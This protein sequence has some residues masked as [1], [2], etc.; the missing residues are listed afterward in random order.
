MG[1]KQI[2]IGQLIAPFG[3]GSLYTDRRGTPHVV[4]GLDH[5]FKRVDQVLGLVLC[6]KRAEFER[7]EPRL[8]D[9]LRVDR[10]CAPPDFRA[11]RRGE[12][13]PPNALLNV[14]AQRFPRWY[15]HTKTGRLRRF[16]LHT[17]KIDR[18]NDGGRYQ[19]V[20]FVSV[21]AGGHLSE[22]PWKEWIGCQCAGDGELVLTD[23]GGSELGSITVN[24]TSCPAGSTGRNGRSLAGTTAKP[25]PGEQS[26]FRRAGITCS[27]DRPWLGDGAN[28]LGCGHDLIGALINQTNLYF[29]RTI[30][31]ILLPDLQLQDDAVAQLRNEI[32]QD[33]GTLGVARTLWNMGNRAGADALI[34]SG[35]AGRGITSNLAQI[36]EA[37]ASLFDPASATLPVGAVPPA[38]PESDLLAFRRA[39]FNIIRNEVNDPEHLPNL[40][41]I[42]ATVPEELAP[43]LIKVNLVER[44]RETRV[45]YGFDR[46][47]QNTSPLAGMP[48]T[49]MR[50]LFRD[51][52]DQPQDR[53]LPAI[54]VFGEGIYVELDGHRITEW[55]YDQAEWL[56]KR[57]DD[58]FVTRIAGVFQTLSPSPATREWAS[59]YLL[60][61]SLAHILINQ[62]VFECGYST[63]ALRERLYVSADAA[64]PMAGFLIFT[65][66]G[67]SEGTL[68]GLVRLGRP[69]RLGPIVQR[70]LSR[71]AW[72]SADPVCSE[73]LGGQGSRLANLA[74][75]HACVL[76]PETSCETINQGLDRAMIVGVPDDRE[77]GFMAELLEG[78]YSLG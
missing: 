2:R 48:D 57:L 27:G 6:D 8:A 51:P 55:Q 73:H 46:L 19:P 78:A 13:A 11:V 41:V 45:F 53:W 69:E 9:L 47:D 10:F 62:L 25:D 17:A 64:A 67:D 59:H 32:E 7:F 43:W 12:T 22:F 52:P 70:A 28:E 21:C 65:A 34:Q 50:Q 75:C 35:L 23:R 37:L 39:E 20:R 24:C 66:A 42:P 30:S 5:W 77:R 31:A 60:V 38:A 56:E 36:E 29:G 33:A 63:A 76:L 44:L 72:C 74:A 40:R 49:A 26:T 1:N 58:G 54:A 68:G 3:P 18:P 16:N 61:H 4:C 14:P 15:R 71:A